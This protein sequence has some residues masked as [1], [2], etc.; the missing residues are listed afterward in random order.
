MYLY[1]TNT[2]LDTVA[3]KWKTTKVNYIGK[4]KIDIADPT[5]TKMK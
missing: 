4:K 5:G 2:P 1:N 3:N